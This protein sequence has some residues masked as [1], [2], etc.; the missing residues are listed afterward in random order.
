V[1]EKVHANLT[2]KRVAMPHDLHFITTF[3]LCL[4]PENSLIIWSKF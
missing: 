1:V 2:A 3:T 4:Q